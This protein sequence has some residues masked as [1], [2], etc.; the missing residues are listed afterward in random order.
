[1]ALTHLGS[2]ADDGY[3]AAYGA[4]V[5]VERWAR[6]NIGRIRLFGVFVHFKY[7]ALLLA[8]CAVITAAVYYCYS[9]AALRYPQA[10]AWIVAK[11]LFGALP[12]TL[13]FAGLGLYSSRQTLSGAGC[14]PALCRCQRYCHNHPV[15]VASITAVVRHGIRLHHTRRAGYC[16]SSQCA[17][18]IWS[19]TGFQFA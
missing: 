9:E 11:S 3:N 13:C 7:F 10:S 6:W 14:H 1:M 19:A 8:E 5:P 15:C 2:E 17:I 12:F 18:N 16:I 4:A